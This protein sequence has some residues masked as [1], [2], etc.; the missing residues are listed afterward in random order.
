MRLLA[1]ALAQRLRTLRYRAVCDK[2]RWAPFS[3][4]RPP[5]PTYLVVNGVHSTSISAPTRWHALDSPIFA[6]Q[7]GVAIPDALASTDVSLN[8]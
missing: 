7:S 6:L 4:V 1:K 8:C 2:K 5:F 3:A